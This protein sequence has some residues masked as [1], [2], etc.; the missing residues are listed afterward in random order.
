MVNKWEIREAVVEDSEKLRLLMESAYSIYKDRMN[1]QT[2]PPLEVDYK[3]EIENFPVWVVEMNSE[4]V[5]AI[6]L[7][8]ETEYCQIANVGVDTNYQGYGIGKGLLKFAES[9]A[10]RMGYSKIKLATHVLFTENLSWYK[11]LGWNE[12]GR[13]ETRIYMEKSL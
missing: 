6:I 3:D 8:Y 4:L 5:G 13:D 7:M 11:I 2:L 10:K 1:G 12:T 9:I